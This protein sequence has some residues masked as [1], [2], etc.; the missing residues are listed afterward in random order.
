MLW[1]YTQTILFCDYLLLPTALWSSGKLLNNYAEWLCQG[2]WLSSLTLVFTS[3]HIYILPLP[4]SSLH[5]FLPLFLFNCEDPVVGTVHPKMNSVIIHLHVVP[6]LF[7]FLSLQWNINQDILRNA[8]FFFVFFL[9]F[10][11]WTILTSQWNHF[12]FDWTDR[13]LTVEPKKEGAFRGVN[14][15]SF[16]KPVLQTS[17]WCLTWMIHSN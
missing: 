6:N 7:H 11:Y 9:F 8:C 15:T 5:L 13:V 16:Q 1:Y 2:S 14:A 4:P 10:V 3:L 12:C 17:E